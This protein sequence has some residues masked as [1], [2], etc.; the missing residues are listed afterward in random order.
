MKNKRFASYFIM[1]FLGFLTVQKRLLLNVYSIMLFVFSASRQF[2]AFFLWRIQD[3]P[4][5]GI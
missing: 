1:F 5:L 2:L 4:G 3:N